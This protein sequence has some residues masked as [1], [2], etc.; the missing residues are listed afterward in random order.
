MQSDL[1][2]IEFH[3]DEKPSIRVKLLHAVHRCPTTLALNIEYGRYNMLMAQDPGDGEFTVRAYETGRLR[4]NDEWHQVPVL[5]SPQT[6]DTQSLPTDLGDLSPEHI[7]TI[8]Q[9]GAEIIVIGTG[10]TQRFLGTELIKSALQFG[11]A[12]DVMDTRA[13]CHTFVVLASEG[14]KVIAV[15]YP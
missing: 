14:R 2:L 6:L 4:I 3:G 7:R 9:S 8:C 1:K 5:I 10:A 15:L 11:R 12:L 13:A